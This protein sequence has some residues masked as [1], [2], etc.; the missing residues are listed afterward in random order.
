MVD[1]VYKQQVTEMVTSEIPLPQSL[2]QLVKRYCLDIV[3]TVCIYIYMFIDGQ[4]YQ[5]NGSYF[6]FNC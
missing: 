6:V 1:F 4:K 2:L 3:H 5:R